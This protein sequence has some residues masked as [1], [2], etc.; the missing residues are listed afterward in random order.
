MQHLSLRGY[1]RRV[2]TLVAALV[3]LSAAGIA[4]EPPAGRG[5]G[6]RGG[7]RPQDTEVWEPVPK[8]VTPGTNDSAP[9]SD[10]VIL[11]DGKNLD[12]WV[13]TRDK[14]PANWTV[15]DGVLTVHKGPGAGNIE[16]KRSFHNYQLHIEWKIPENVTGTD[17]LRGNSGIFLAS[18]GA[19]DAGYELQI[20]DSYNNKTYVNGQ[21]G[22]IYKQDIPLVNPARKPGEW[23]SYDVVWMAPVFQP[24]GSLKTPAYVTVFFNGVLVQNHFELTGETLY[25]GKPSYRKFDSAPIKL[26]AHPD[27]SEPVSFRNIWLRDLH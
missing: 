19:G 4:Q 17:Q 10:A 20:L 27:P 2:C 25:I 9:P 24:D 1:S 3:A 16:T 22:S 5:G 21:A 11:F 13:N 18:T 7:G 12:E 26:Q 14:S 23:Q 6:R 8:V 15:H